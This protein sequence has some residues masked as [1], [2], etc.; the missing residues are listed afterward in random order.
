[1]KAISMRFGFLLLLF[2]LP[3][4]VAFSETERLV[5]PFVITLPDDLQIFPDEEDLPDHVL[6]LMWTREI[7]SQKIVELRQ[8]SEER[9]SDDLE[10]AIASG[11]TGNV[12]LIVEPIQAALLGME[13]EEQHERYCDDFRKR[14]GYG[15][16]KFD[17]VRQIGHCASP[18]GA[19]TYVMCRYFKRDRICASGI[20]FVELLTTNSFTEGTYWTEMIDA[21]EEPSSK[22]AAE[23]VLSNMAAGAAVDKVNDLLVR[24]RLRTASE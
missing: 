20:D 18:V 5:D 21:L 8:S 10:A 4:R 16:S 6:N 12:I 17:H 19:M 22:E 2:L 24:F 13:A 11:N 9:Q 15:F 23:K 1:M 14:W 3:A 7:D